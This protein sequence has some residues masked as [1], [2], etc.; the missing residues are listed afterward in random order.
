MKGLNENQNLAGPEKWAH[1]KKDNDPNYW[2]VD[3]AA[4]PIF[5]A[6]SRCKR[7]SVIYSIFARLFLAPMML[8]HHQKSKSDQA[9]WEKQVQFITEYET[10][11]ELL[12]KDVNKNLPS[13]TS[14]R[15][16]QEMVDFLGR[17]GHAPSLTQEQS[18]NYSSKTSS[19][20]TPRRYIAFYQWTR[21]YNASRLPEY[22]QRVEALYTRQL[23]LLFQKDL[24]GLARRLR[25]LISNLPEKG[26][27]LLEDSAAPDEKIL[28]LAG[29]ILSCTLLA[30]AAEKSRDGEV[31]EMLHQHFG[32]PMPV[33][34]GIAGKSTCSMVSLP[35]KTVKELCSLLCGED[36]SLSAARAMLLLLRALPPIRQAGYEEILHKRLNDLRTSTYI[37]I[38]QERSQEKRRQMLAETQE[39]ES[40]EEELNR[41]K[42]P[43]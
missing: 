40:L 7:Q 31:Y 23:M 30:S 26:R 13:D 29:R 8:P 6:E 3:S 38:S 21:N 43:P 32:M 27:F 17:E 19:Y 42:F 5:N 11:I 36:F 20:K 14:G 4:I 10:A 41:L 22:I 25:Y 39:L 35:M 16:A 9:I 37:L 24:A 28:S 2:Y 12:E 34:V 18:N 33:N 15:R 1:E